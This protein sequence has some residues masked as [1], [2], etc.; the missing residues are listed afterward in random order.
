M[1]FSNMHNS[2]DL[3]F[4]VC[5]KGFEEFEDM[6]V[7]KNYVSACTCL[8]NM[9]LQES[10]RQG[11]IKTSYKQYNVT[12]RESL[13]ANSSKKSKQN[14]ASVLDVPRT[15]SDMVSM[16][17]AMLLR[18]LQNVSSVSNGNAETS[19]LTNQQDGIRKAIC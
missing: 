14:T 18:L 16:F 10:E 4:Q 9:R 7:H 1:N 3:L 8:L 15:F 19:E 6:D 5:L 17:A 11:D 12:L 13:N 2:F